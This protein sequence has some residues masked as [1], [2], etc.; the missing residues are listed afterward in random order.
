MVIITAAI[1]VRVQTG[2][3]AT[4]IQIDG[5]N[6]RINGA[7]TYPHSLAQGLLMNVRMVNAVFEDALLPDFDP[8]DNTAEFVAMIPEYV[9]LGIRAFTIS[10]Q[11][12]NPD[13][14]GAINSAFNSDG[15]L[16]APYMH[17]VSQVIEAADSAGAV[18]ILSLFYQ[19]QDQILRNE[20]AVR[21]A[22]VNATEWVKNKG[23]TNVIIEIANEHPHSGFLHAIIRTKAGMVSLIQL[24]RSV[25][26]TLYFAASGTGS[27]TISSEVAKVSD[28]LLVH[29]NGTSVSKIP[30]KIQALKIHGKPIVC[31][32]DD[33]TGLLAAQAAEASVRNG[34]SYGLMVAEVNQD[35]PFEFHGRDDDPVAYD[36]I[37]RLTSSSR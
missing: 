14:E 6:F 23:Y 15:S 18:I 12:G 33:K 36:K 4:R 1:A 34:A 25:A 29:F 8:E 13:Y 35:F 27:G 20:A 37:S 32:E 3:A 24:A 2:L 16:K 30:S 31:N 11:G 26:P 9:S 21:A 19:R 5:R 22:V 10:L 7:L 28:V 17:R